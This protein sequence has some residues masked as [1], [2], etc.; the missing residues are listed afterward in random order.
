MRRIRMLAIAATVVIALKASPLPAHHSLGVYDQTK[1]VTIKGT[2]AQILWRN[3]HTW[4]VL[5]ISNTDGTMATQQVEIAG[6]SRLLQTGFSQSSL[7]I[8]DSV[9]FEVWFP[10]DPRY[11]NGP[12][13]RTVTLA[14][15]RKFDVAD[16]WLQSRP[17]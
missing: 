9:T 5:N 4:V 8:G 13:G 15:G 3:P 1:L 11:S 7:N 17:R 10:L 6:P 16:N 2:V 14:D 12:A